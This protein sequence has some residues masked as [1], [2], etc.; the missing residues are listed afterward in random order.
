MELPLKEH[1]FSGNGPSLVLHFLSRIVKE[2]NI[3]D[4]SEAQ[5]FIALPSF[6]EGFYLSEYDDAI[7]FATQKNVRISSRP[8]MYQ[9]LL[10]RYAQ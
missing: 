1:N 6:L 5:A 2:A 10:Q 8:D 9:H 7:S 3:H 4:M